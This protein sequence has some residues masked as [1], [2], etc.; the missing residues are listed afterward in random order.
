MGGY[1]R[2]TVGCYIAALSALD[3][4]DVV[5]LWLQCRSFVF[6]RDRV[7]QDRPFR[8]GWPEMALAE[9]AA[10]VWLDDGSL[11]CAIRL[12]Q[13][14]RCVLAVRRSDVLRRAQAKVPDRRDA[15]ALVLSGR[16]LPR[17]WLQ[18]PPRVA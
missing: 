4:R 2:F 14:R 10:N 9:A 6:R 12:L 3:R 11:T 15:A 1:Y 8:V 17:L 13:E 5:N 16:V 7:G 18:S